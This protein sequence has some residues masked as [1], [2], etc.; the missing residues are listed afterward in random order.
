MSA[1]QGFNPAVSLIPPNPSA[2]IVPFQGGGG[3]IQPFYQAIIAGLPEERRKDL[4]KQI[5]ILN[6]T[7]SVEDGKFILKLRVK[8]KQGTEEE[9]E[10]EN[11]DENEGEDENEIIKKAKEF[12]ILEAAR[13]WLRNVSTITLNN[14]G[15][16]LNLGQEKPPGPTQQDYNNLGEELNL[17]QEKPPTLSTP[18]TSQK[19]PTS[20]T[21]S[22]PPQ[23]PPLQQIPSTLSKNFLQRTRLHVTFQNATDT[24]NAARRLLQK[25]ENNSRKKFQVGLIQR[26]PRTQITATNL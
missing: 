13:N 5:Q 17:G 21:S 6:F 4:P 26:R 14:L 25:E 3:S 8:G 15:D 19:P 7:I 11:E 16:E 1:P 22:N 10:N 9:D 2:P 12:L 24:M 18:P 23:N 20:S